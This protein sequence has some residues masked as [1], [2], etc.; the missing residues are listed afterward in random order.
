MSLLDDFLCYN[1][2]KVKWEE[3][4]KTTFITNWGTLTHE[5]MLSGLPDASTTFKRPIQITPDEL[6]S[7]HIYLD[8]L[9]IYSKGP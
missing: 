6:I 5:C 1:Q 4:Y 8:D 3:A 9:I 2:I 7:V